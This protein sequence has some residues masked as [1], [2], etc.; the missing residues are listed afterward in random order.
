MP[1]SAKKR[2]K[3]IRSQLKAIHSADQR[4]AGA[5]QTTPLKFF[6]P[7]SS[8]QSLS[9]SNIAL[10][11]LMRRDYCKRVFSSAMKFLIHNHMY[12]AFDA[13]KRREDDWEL[14]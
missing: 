9:S 13:F 10:L 5:L 11:S 1:G 6:D 8:G 12:R 3:S 14:I 7:I 4:A 2:A